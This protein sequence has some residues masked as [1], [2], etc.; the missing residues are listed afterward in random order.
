MDA[1]V[2]TCLDSAAQCKTKCYLKRAV[3]NP[4]FIPRGLMIIMIIRRTIISSS[5][6]SSRSSSS[7]SS[8]SSDSMS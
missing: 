7:S 5:S 8:S 6:S 1:C 3:Q 4:T 2:I